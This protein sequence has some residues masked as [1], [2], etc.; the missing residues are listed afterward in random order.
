[1]I[2]IYMKTHIA[3]TGRGVKIQNE[4]KGVANL[5]NK[6]LITGIEQIIRR[7]GNNFNHDNLNFKNC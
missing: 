1:M 6:H 7:S 5:S 3:S 2:E 4:R